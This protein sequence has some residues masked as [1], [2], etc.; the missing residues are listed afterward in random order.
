MVAITGANG[1]LGNFIL[2]KFI[3]EKTSVVALKRQGSDL[4]FIADGLKD[5]EWR[6]ADVQDSTSLIEALKNIDTVI[7]A[8]AVVSFDPRAKERIYKTNVEGT[9]NVVNAC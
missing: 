2:K 4:S 3:D 6:N 1:L 7:H 8:A 5:V 9:R